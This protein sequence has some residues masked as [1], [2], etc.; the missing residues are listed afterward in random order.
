MIEKIDDLTAMGMTQGEGFE[1]RYQDDP[2]IR[3]DQPMANNKDIFPCLL[4]MLGSGCGSM[5]V[6]LFSNFIN[7][8]S[9]KS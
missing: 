7:Q 8:R 4:I 2:K 3:S 9:I 5:L 6:K 1:Y